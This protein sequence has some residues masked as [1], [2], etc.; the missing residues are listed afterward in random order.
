[1]TDVSD[2]I[3]T[4]TIEETNDQGEAKEARCPVTHSA[5]ADPDHNKRWW[6]NRLNI[7]ILAKNSPARNPLGEEF[8]YV[9]AFEALDLAE[10][11]KD[12]AHVMTDSK[13][14]W[15]ADFGTYA[16]FMIRMAWHAATAGSK[17]G[18][19]TDREGALTND[20]LVTL[21]DLETSWERGE[22][23]LYNGKNAT[24]GATFT[25]SRADLVFGANSELRA[26]AEVYASDD[27]REKFTRDFVDAWVK[28]MELD[29]FDLHR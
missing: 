2:P 13:D 6:P 29:R 3:E 17:V 22:G 7:K 28:V 1:M 23:D 26:V 25:G 20:F 4:T 8:D 16:P 21:L 9:K 5:A 12:I 24:S 14:W 11:K 10:V 15:P 27:A 19:L 18:V